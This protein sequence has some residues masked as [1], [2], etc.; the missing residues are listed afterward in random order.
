MGMMEEA[1]DGGW[2]HG[3]TALVLVTAAAVTDFGR[4]GLPCHRQCAD[5]TFPIHRAHGAPD[6]RVR[7][8][9]LVLVRQTG[10]VRWV[11]RLEGCLSDG[12]R[13]SG[14]REV[15]HL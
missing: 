11:L 15:S 6:G 7:H 3:I 2:M 5:A 4:N 10:S 14:R 1:P 9:S 8:R 13:Q 12:A